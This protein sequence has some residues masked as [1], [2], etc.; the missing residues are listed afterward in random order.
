VG[1]TTDPESARSTLHCS[2]LGK[3]FDIPIFHVNADDPEAVQRVF[4]TAAAYRL[5]FKTDVIVDLVGYRKYGHNE[6]D[7]PMFTQP[8]MYSKIAQHPTALDIYGAKLVAEGSVTSEELATV[9]AGV[10]KTFAEAWLKAQEKGAA[11]EGAAA[12]AGAIEWLTSKW[13]GFNSPA[14]LS[15]IRPTGVPSSV[16]KSVGA[17]LTAIPSSIK[18]HPSLVRIIKAKEDMIKSGEGLDWATAEALAFGSLLLEGNRVRLSGQDVER[19]TFSHRHAVLHD[20]TSS[21]V[22]TPLANLDANQA[23]FLASNS[24]L[25]EFGVM[26]FEL[27]YSMEQPNQL[28]LWEAQVRLWQPSRQQKQ[29]AARST[30]QLLR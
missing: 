26:G 5:R 11:K 15:R 8:V 12:A 20:Q 3:A 6:L 30:R 9:R 4:E 14:S 10:E 25:S 22:Y 28:V 27:G 18:L 17:A 16:L 23:P 13:E 19:G 29:A 2:D 21:A 1:F 7:Q 24:L